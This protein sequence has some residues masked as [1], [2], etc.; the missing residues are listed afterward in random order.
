[1]TT[2]IESNIFNLSLKYYLNPITAMEI[3][4]S[5]ANT[6]VKIILINSLKSTS[7][8]VIGYLSKAK[9]TMF[10]IIQALI[11]NWNFTELIIFDRDFLIP[12]RVISWFC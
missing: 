5:K 12:W 9:N 11:N 3:N 7:D 1:M 2:I 4:S 10:V 8:W 6:N